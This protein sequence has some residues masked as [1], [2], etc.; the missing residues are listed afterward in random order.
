MHEFTKMGGMIM[1]ES[2]IILQFQYLSKST[3]M[4]YLL[5]MSK[6]VPYISHKPPKRYSTLF[7]P[8]SNP[9]NLASLFPLSC[10]VPTSPPTTGFLLTFDSFS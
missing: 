5:R 7:F 4:P 8:S 2:S 9:S 1:Y 6:N 3:V 10:L